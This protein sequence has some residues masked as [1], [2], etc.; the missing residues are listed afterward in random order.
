MQR[1][2]FLACGIIALLSTATGTRNWTNAREH[3]GVE[4]SHQA[5]VRRPP[6]DQ[7]ASMRQQNTLLS[8]CVWGGD[9]MLV[10]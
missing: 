6:G 4:R 3:C 1:W 7:G 2:T 8:V 5:M 9:I 10:D